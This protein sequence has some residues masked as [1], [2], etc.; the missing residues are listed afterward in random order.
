VLIP[1]EGQRKKLQ[2]NREQ[3]DGEQE[4]KNR[5]IAPLFFCG[6]PTPAFLDWHSRLI[7][8]LLDALAGSLLRFQMNFAEGRFILLQILL[9]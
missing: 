2:M 5:Q 8:W 9:Q 3:W 6:M 7:A 4:E 1:E